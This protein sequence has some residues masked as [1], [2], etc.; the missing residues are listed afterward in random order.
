[1]Y[2]SF[3]SRATIL[4]VSIALCESLLA[5]GAGNASA[6]TAKPEY[7]IA[8]LGPLSGGNSTLGTNMET[9]VKLAVV[10]AN[11]GKT[12]GKLPF[13]LV[14]MPVDDE[15]LAGPAPA[16]AKQLVEDTAV[17]AVVGPAF[18][19]DTEAAEPVFA[20]AHLATVSSS[21]TAPQLTA[22]GW[23]NFFRVVADDNT[24]GPADAAFVAKELHLK[25]VYSVDDGSQYGAGIANA[26][27]QEASA[28][29]VEV[30]HQTA[31]GTTICGAGNGNAD[32]YGPLSVK[33]VKSKAQLMF[34][35]GA[36]C[37]LVLF[38]KALRSKGYK[39]RLMSDD[40]SLDPHYAAELGNAAADGTYL[41]CAC[42]DLTDNKAD[43][44]FANAFLKLSGNP[45]G[46][47]SPE[48]Y[49]AANTII[50]VLKTLGPGHITRA[51]VIKGLRK[52]AYKGLTKTVHFQAD[53]DMAG[54]SV[55]LYEIENGR[56]EQ[57]GLLP[58][59]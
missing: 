16:A 19:L 54:P 11:K 55:Y 44:A 37:D 3:R 28:L 50:D 1:M 52:V 56:A 46:Q 27:D 45:S 13:K 31:P 57:V 35:G 34:Y 20:S 5:A 10:Q 30:Q 36:F 47:W 14:F 58:W 38:V 7:T 40:M 41:S 9:S 48:S 25:S 51:A 29:H 21:A 43:V 15:G 26:F 8:Y 42:A 59:S 18:T 23:T 4:A 32:Q 53:G 33:I 6:T 2:R 49:D 12:F 22:H 17:V 24:Q 39:G